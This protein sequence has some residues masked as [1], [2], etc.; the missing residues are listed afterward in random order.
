[1]SECGMKDRLAQ[2]RSLRDK[3]CSQQKEWK[4]GFEIRDWIVS[5]LREVRSLISDD[6]HDHEAI[7][8]KVDSILEALDPQE[9]SKDV[10]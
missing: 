1:M 3:L 6:D 7:L 5:E 8:V 9:A 4:T 10:G 2:L